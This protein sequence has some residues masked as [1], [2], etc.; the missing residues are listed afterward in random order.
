MIEQCPEKKDQISEAIRASQNPAWGVYYQL[1]YTHV[2][3]ERFGPAGLLRM[4]AKYLE[5]LEET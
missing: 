2:H 3:N 4:M 1:G 5:Y